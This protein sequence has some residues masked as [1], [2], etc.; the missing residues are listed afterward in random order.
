MPP[1]N[2]VAAAIERWFPDHA[3]PLSWRTTPRDPWT[4]LVA[5]FMLQQTQVSRVEERLAIMLD[6]FPTPGHMASSS[7]DDVLALW[8]GLGYYRR[9]RLLH[10][11]SVAMVASHGGRVPEDARALRSLP[12]IGPYSAGSIASICFGQR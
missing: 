11:A 12:G 1:D 10:A 5:E 4:S 2:E 7:V 3:R 9:A 8:S 6:R